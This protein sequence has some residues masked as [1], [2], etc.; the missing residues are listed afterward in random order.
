MEAR[1]VAV[2]EAAMGGEKGAVVTGEVMAAVVMVA[3]SPPGGV[4]GGQPA[5][6]PWNEWRS[7]C[8]GSRTNR[9]IRWCCM[10]CTRSTRG[11][12]SSCWRRNRCS[13]R[14]PYK[15]RGTFRGSGCC[16]FLSLPRRS[17]T[18]HLSQCC[19][20]LSDTRR[21][22]RDSCCSTTPQ[23]SRCH[24]KTPCPRIGTRERAETAHTKRDESHSCC[25]S[26]LT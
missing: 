6:T 17:N 2:R 18:S 5:A 8:T 26:G 1:E 4:G 22:E 24:H 15:W 20:A 10:T 3:V 16:T 9:R 14:W 23:R 13:L 11:N 7:H 21:R 12:G 25:T 19:L